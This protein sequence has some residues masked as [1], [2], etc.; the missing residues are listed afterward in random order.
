MK[1]GAHHQYKVRQVEGVDQGALIIMLYDGAIKFLT[2][3]IEAIDNK[4]IETAHNNIIRGQAVITELIN[5][6]K[7]DTGEV[8]VNLLRLYEFMVRQLGVANAKKDKH[9]INGVIELLKSLKDGWLAII[10]KLREEAKEEKADSE[11]EDAEEAKK[12]PI[13]FAV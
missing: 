13:N 3:A 11:T 2:F 12:A 5:S 9:V 4:E 10:D 1:N 6:L 8:V 7:V